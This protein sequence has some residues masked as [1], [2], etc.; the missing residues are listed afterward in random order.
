MTGD[1]DGG[2]DVVL[3][4]GAG[5]GRGASGAAEQAASSS[6]EAAQ[7]PPR[8]AV[9]L[10]WLTQSTIGRGWV[11][12]RLAGARLLRHHDALRPGRGNGCR[13]T[14]SWTTGFSDW[15]G[16]GR[17]AG[18]SRRH[19]PEPRLHPLEDVRPPRRPAPRAAR[20]ARA[21]RA[22]LASTAS[23]GPRCAA[24]ASDA[25]TPRGRGGGRSWPA[26]PN[27]DLLEGQR[28]VHRPAAAGGRAAPTATPRGDRRQVVLA[29]GSRRS[30]PTSPA[31][32]DLPHHTSDTIM[33]I[34]AP[35]PARRPRR[36]VRRLPSSPTS[37]PRSAPGSPRSTPPHRLLGNQDEEIADR[38]H[39]WLRRALGRA[40]GDR[41]GADHAPATA[42]PLH[43]ADGTSRGRRR[44][45][46]WP[47]DARPN[48]DR[49]DLER[50]GVEVDDEGG[51]WSTT[52][53]AP[54]PTASG[55]WA[56]SRRA[57]PQAR[58]QPGRPRRPAQPAAPRRPRGY[59]T[60]GSCP[61]RSSHTPR[62]PRWA[63][64]R[65]RPATGLDLAV[66]RTSTPTRPRAGP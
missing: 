56:T 32:H 35:G 20:R 36:R 12:G 13:A 30:Y 62:W 5:A 24:R 61:T 27:V 7:A 14:P 53:S 11:V 52:T 66:G 60:T 33:R 18:P 34:E 39:R 63:S 17:R 49:L 16:G 1:G 22:H 8:R 29:T 15:S 44:W 51:S 9:R 65:P 2:A 55:P 54:P 58:G 37:S 38:V 28:A 19:L 64:P 57:A 31:W 48:G 43:L 25:S 47:S 46:W 21:R 26:R 6:A 50:A 59:P 3:D 40:P 41:A 42:A 10:A 23:T 4:G 45:C